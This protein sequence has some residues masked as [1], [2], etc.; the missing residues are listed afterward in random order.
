MTDTSLSTSRA[1]WFSIVSSTL[2]AVVVGF[3][4]TILVI[5]EAARN[6]GATPSQQASWAAALCI[7][8]AVSSF[9]LSWR[10]R[11]PMI[12]AWS[13]PGAVLIATSGPGISYQNALGAFVVAGLLMVV[14]GLIKPLEKAIEKIPAPIAAAMLAGVL[15]RYTLG[16]PGAAMAMP[17]AVLPLVVVFFG[18]QAVL[19][20]LCGAGGGGAG[21][22]HCG[23]SAA[24][25]RAIAAASASRRSN[26]R[27]PPSTC[28][29]SCR[30]ACRCSSSPWRRRTCRASRC[31]GPAATSRRCSRRCS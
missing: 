7:G 26:G 10:Y 2:T 6:V 5:M 22:G 21:R 12:T 11:M 28:R 13:T 31:C 19:S 8:M 20:A 27:R 1:G 24:A 23:D 16:V 29:P 25:L 17:L 3:A 18:L 14:A 15:L 30:S 4:S 9:F